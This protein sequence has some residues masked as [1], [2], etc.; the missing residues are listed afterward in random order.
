LKLT[1]AVDGPAGAG[2]S[3]IAKIISE[4]FD[5]MYINTGSM[6]RAVALFALRNNIS[7]EDTD[8]LCRLIG[9]LKMHFDKNRLIVN[10]EDVSELIVHPDISKRVSEYAAVREVRE[11][12]VKLQQDMAVQYSVIMDGRDIGTVVLK[13]AFIKFYLIASAEE[14]ARRRYKELAEK[15]LDVHYET[16][17]EDINRRDYIDSNRECNPLKKAADAIE[18]DS[19][20]LNIDEVVQVMSEYIEEKMKK[21]NFTVD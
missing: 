16:I 3:T 19:S 11:L 21:N 15:G 18:I 9:S 8:G 14:R 1:I 6:Y 13:D 7:P 20:L 17:L 5:T 10:G 2:K 4:K 12:L